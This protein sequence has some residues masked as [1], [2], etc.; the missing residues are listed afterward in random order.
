MLNLDSPSTPLNNFKIQKTMD[1]LFNTFVVDPSKSDH[2][3]EFKS[4]IEDESTIVFVV[5][6]DDSTAEQLIMS[7]DILADGHTGKIV[8]KAA[9]IKDHELLK[10]DCL[11]YLKTFE[12]YDAT[13]YEQTLAYV[14]SPRHHECKYVFF[15]GDPIASF[16]VSKAYWK[17]SLREREET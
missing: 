1:E 15:D 13:R 14:I 7:A 5:I 2:K 17:A 16:N 6:G 4:L 9:W 11:F 8:R 10:E 12:G 3:E